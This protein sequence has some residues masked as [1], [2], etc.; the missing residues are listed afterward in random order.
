MKQ[1]TSFPY[2]TEEDKKR[3]YKYLP[4]VKAVLISKLKAEGWKEVW[5]R[6]LIWLMRK[7]GDVYTFYGIINKT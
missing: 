6:H 4:C 7:E 2:P 3:L 5:I 1:K